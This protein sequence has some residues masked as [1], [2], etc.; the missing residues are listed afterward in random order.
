MFPVL[1]EDDAEDNSSNEYV[2]VV[3]ENGRVFDV[4]GALN[5]TRGG[6]RNGGI[7]DEVRKIVLIL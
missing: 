6:R 7:I 5:S 1:K 4:V 2:T 3:F